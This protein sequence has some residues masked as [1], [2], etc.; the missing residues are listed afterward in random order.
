[1][2]MAASML[3]WKGYSLPHT[4]F[5]KDQRLTHAV[6]TEKVPF[7]KRIGWCLNDVE[8]GRPAQANAKKSGGRNLNQYLLTIKH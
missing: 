1:M 8:I 4:V 2:R 3:R 5:D 7:T 6:I